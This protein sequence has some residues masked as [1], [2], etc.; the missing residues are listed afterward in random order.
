MP[1]IRNEWPAIPGVLSRMSTR[2]RKYL[3]E[4]MKKRTLG[5]NHEVA[6]SVSVLPP[7]TI[8]DIAFF[9]TTTPSAAYLSAWSHRK[10]RQLV[11]QPRLAQQV[12]KIVVTERN[13]GD[14]LGHGLEWRRDAD[15]LRLDHT[16]PIICAWL[17]LFKSLPNLSALKVRRPFTAYDKDEWDQIN[18]SDAVTVL[19]SIIAGTRLPLESFEV[20]LE[21]QTDNPIDLRR[22]NRRDLIDPGFLLVWN[23]LKPFSLRVQIANAHAAGFPY[24]LLHNCPNLKSLSLN[25]QHGQHASS[26]INLESLSIRGIELLLRH[27]RSLRRLSLMSITFPDSGLWRWLFSILREECATLGSIEVN[28][29]R[30]IC[31]EATRLINFPEVPTTST[32]HSDGV[33]FVYHSRR[34]PATATNRRAPLR[35]F[36]ISY[37]GP[38]MDKALK[39][40]DNWAEALKV[41]P[42]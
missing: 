27:K 26:V 7:E 13:F 16:Q 39:M 3:K 4:H 25:F 10:L 28:D 32:K 12:R 19:V 37:E 11:L 2:F 15:G 20:D 22:I 24:L 29:L 8:A 17:A 33:R 36:D 30:E 31:Y 9:L 42:A 34:W 23:Q 40:M 38:E 14:G 18:A 21:P 41:G 35:N 6:G 1:G 5:P